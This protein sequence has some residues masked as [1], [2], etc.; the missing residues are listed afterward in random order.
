M[1]YNLN[2]MMCVV[3]MTEELSNTFRK[4]TQLVKLLPRKPCDEDLL[5]LYGYYKQVY[6][7]NCNIGEPNAFFGI[8]EH[9]KWCA[10]KSLENMESS[11]AMKLYIQKVNQLIESYK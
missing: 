7:G 8:K 4:Y 6:N 11:L 10:W 3:H 2:T 5:L 1:F 9:R